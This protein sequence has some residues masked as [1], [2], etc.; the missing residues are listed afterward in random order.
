MAVYSTYPCPNCGDDINS[1]VWLPVTTR[2]RCRTCGG[3]VRRCGVSIRDAWATSFALLGFAPL[4]WLFTLS[5]VEDEALRGNLVVAAYQAL[6][7]AT[8]TSMTAMSAV[9][10][11]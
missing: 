11:L 10:W 6:F 5:F 2:D 4:W 9:G 1:R 8:L 3:P 7:V